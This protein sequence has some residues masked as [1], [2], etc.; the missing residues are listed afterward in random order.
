V[1]FA[2]KFQI[3]AVKKLP[4]S[5]RAFYWSFLGQVLALPDFGS[6]EDTT[7]PKRWLTLKP[8]G[9]ANG[10]R[11]SYPWR[12]YNITNQRIVK[13]I[14]SFAALTMSGAALATNIQRIA[15]VGRSEPDRCPNR[16][17][18][19]PAQLCIGWACEPPRRW[20]HAA[21]PPCRR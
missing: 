2:Q 18:G 20:R 6:R 8:V 11:S 9:E 5:C 1:R 13:L 14:L 19:R 10:V 3:R 16:L 15:T 12:W 17:A 21:M 4:E 7:F